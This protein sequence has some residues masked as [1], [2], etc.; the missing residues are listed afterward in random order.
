MLLFSGGF[1]IGNITTNLI[2]NPSYNT[3]TEDSLVSGA[4]RT[5]N[6]PTVWEDYADELLNEIPLDNI[7]NIANFPREHQNDSLYGKI[8]YMSSGETLHN[9]TSERVYGI[10]RYSA[11]ERIAPS[12]EP[13][14]HVKDVA[15]KLYKRY[16]KR[17]H[18]KR[19]RQRRR[20]RLSKK[21]NQERNL[22]RRVHRNR[23]H[24]VKNKRRRRKKLR[25]S[26]SRHRRR[27]RIS[28][29]GRQKPAG[30]LKN[31]GGTEVT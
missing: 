7:T 1:G 13:P 27:H 12:T 9:D 16:H 26:Q 25:S 19:R 22:G 3:K 11:E 17:R 4:T 15:W 5:Q 20:H 30:L 2:G 8:K 14:I 10:M 28:R 6:R 29:R 23:S 21:R 31:I 18:R 24:G